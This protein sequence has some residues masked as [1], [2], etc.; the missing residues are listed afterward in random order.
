MNTDS[1]SAQ[2]PDSL[3]RATPITEIELLYED[4]YSVI[5]EFINQA[6]PGEPEE[7]KPTI[8]SFITAEE[9]ASHAPSQRTANDLM[10]LYDD[11]EGLT[12]DE[13]RNE[14]EEIFR[15]N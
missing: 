1:S 2:H 11:G 8:W 6:G 15:E 3:V 14:A 9:L 7:L 4:R 10:A 12:V 13:M 5:V